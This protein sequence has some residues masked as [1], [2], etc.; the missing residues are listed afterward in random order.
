MTRTLELLVNMP[1]V[2]EQANQTDLQRGGFYSLEAANLL[3][4]IEIWSLVAYCQ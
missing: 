1:D 3:K 2:D 4:A